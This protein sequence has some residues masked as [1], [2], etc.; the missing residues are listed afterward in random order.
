[1]IHFLW[2][3]FVSPGTSPGQHR[4]CTAAQ[5]AGKVSHVFLVSEWSAYCATVS[6]QSCRNALQI[7]SW[8]DWGGF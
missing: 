8:D 1:L 6:P 4:I 7:L 2:H 3:R 5:A